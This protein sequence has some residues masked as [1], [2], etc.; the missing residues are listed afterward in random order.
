MNRSG[1]ALQNRLDVSA[2][3]GCNAV[4]MARGLRA[5]GDRTAAGVSEDNDELCTGN[6]AGVFDAAQHLTSGD[7]AGDSHA[8]D[9]AEPEVEEQFSRRTRVDAA[10]HDRNGMLPGSR[11]GEL[12]AQ[13]SLQPSTFAKAL[14]AFE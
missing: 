10:Q 8:E 5:G 9:V 4:W 7:V 6:N 12:L 11:G 2:A 14:V 3:W 1:D 13:V